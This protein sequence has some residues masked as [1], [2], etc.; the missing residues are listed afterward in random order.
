[1][2]ARL[3][4]APPQTS[5][6]PAPLRVVALLL[7]LACGAAAATALACR[8][9]AWSTP[10][11]NASNAFA[12]LFVTHEPW[13][14]GMSAIA[15][16]MIAAHRRTIPVAESLLARLSTDRSLCLIAALVLLVT[17]AGTFFICHDFPLAMDEFAAQFQADIFSAGKLAAPLPHPWLEL[18]PGLKPVFIFL[19]ASRTHWHAGYLPIYSALRALL[20]L[21]GLSSLTNPLLAAATVLVLAGVARRIWPEKRTAAIAAVLM[22]TTSA[23]FLVTSMTA[24]AMPA[25][26]LFNLTWLWLYL[27]PDERR[28]WVTPWLGVLA[29]GLHQPFCHALFAAP[30]L[31]RLVL[32]RHWKTSAYFAAVYGAGLLGWYLWWVRHNPHVGGSAVLGLPSTW[33]LAAQGINIALILGWLSL[34]ILVGLP[35]ALLR[36][37]RLPTVLRDAA[38]G[39]ALTLLFYVFFMSDQGH[40]WG[41][42]YVYPVLGNVALLATAGWL[43]FR[44]TSGQERASVLL[45]FSTVVALALQLPLRAWQVQRFIRP[46]AQASQT[47]ENSGADVVLID[48]REGWYAADLVRNDP[49]LRQTPKVLFLAA[50]RPES[51]SRLP[52][53]TKAVLLRG[54]E[55]AQLGLVTEKAAP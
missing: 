7:A 20:T 29:I 31:L 33:V 30:F 5:A 52:R 15:F 37:S 53:E 44:E 26:L 55:L 23:Q 39:C 6:S 43:L 47:I 46:F 11:A 48:H 27:A 49:F 21:P 38:F 32:E 51:L 17:A 9:Y 2:V 16:A 25:H 1:M 22:L 4:A 28:F 54:D 18:A 50:V 24:Y 10:A 3:A 34:A 19:D 42:R 14:L 41:Y 12:C 40:G 36:F 45:A 13:A 8:G 35:L